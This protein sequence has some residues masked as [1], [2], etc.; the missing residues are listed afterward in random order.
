[1]PMFECL[2]AFLMVE[3]LSGETFVPSLGSPGYKRLL[4]PGRGP[5]RSKDGYIALLPH[6]DANWRELCGLIG[7]TELLADR[8]FESVTAR[9]AN[10]HVI[11]ATLAEICGSRTN[12]EWISLLKGSNI[13]HG[14]VM[15]LEDLLE[16]DQLAATGFWKEFDHPT[17]GRIRMPDIPARFSRTPA[18]IGRLQPR[19]GEH[20]V[21]ILGEA[22]FS[23]AEIEAFIA[24]G[25][26]RDG[27]AH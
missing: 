4:N 19:L 18:A 1:V 21:E 24:A 13:P 16:S 5:Y 7:R 20:S 9:L 27:G 23:S 25:I 15:S 14:P 8:R 3:H 11:Q 26:T 10:V 17:E 2:V 12:A 22:G 6:T